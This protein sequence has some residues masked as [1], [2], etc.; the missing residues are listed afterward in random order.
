[1][2]TITFRIDEEAK[3]KFISQIYKYHLD[4]ISQCLRDYINFINKSEDPSFL[5]DFLAGKLE[6]QMDIASDLNEEPKGRITRTSL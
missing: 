4:N 3:N 1:M 2:S 6:P 5:L